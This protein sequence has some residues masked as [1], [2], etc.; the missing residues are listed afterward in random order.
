MEYLEGTGPFPERAHLVAMFADLGQRLT[1]AID[2]WAADSIREV[3]SWSTTKD[4]GLTERTKQ[5]LARIVDAAHPA[6]I[7]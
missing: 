1:S 3:S 7:G 4:L 6:G 2:D 5:T